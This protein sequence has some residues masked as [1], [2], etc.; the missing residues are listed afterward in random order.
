MKI[1]TREDV[2]VYLGELLHA[3]LHLVRDSRAHQNAAPPKSGVYSA[4][5]G[6]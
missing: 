5:T 3:S 6:K 4:K 2:P 1:L